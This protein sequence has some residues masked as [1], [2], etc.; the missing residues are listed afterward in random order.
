MPVPAPQHQPGSYRS[1]GENDHVPSDD[2]PGD[3]LVQWG[4]S[5]VVLS[6]GRD[7][8]RTAFFEAFP[9]DPNTFIR[10]EGATIG[11]AEAA[12]LARWS[13][14]QGCPAHEFERGAYR[15]GAGACKHCGLFNG[16]AF[17][18]LERCFVCAAPTFY[19]YGADADGTMYWYCEAHAG[20]RDRALHPNP[21]DRYRDEA[22]KD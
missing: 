15:N 22:D 17:E 20:Q 7:T 5:G 21:F 10:G 16:E 14:I 4:S 8:Y 9:S 2:W 12:A 11:E 19:A 1:Q 3:C 18:P 6:R 13:R